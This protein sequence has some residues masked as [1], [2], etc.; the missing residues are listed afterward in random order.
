MLIFNGELK[1]SPSCGFSVATVYR[2][3]WLAFNVAL[4]YQRLMDYPFS[5]SGLVKF[6]TEFYGDLPLKSRMLTKLRPYYC[7]LQE[8]AASVPI[9]S[10]VFDI[11]CGSGLLVTFL[12]AAGRISKGA[13]VDSNA[14]AIEAAMNVTRKLKADLDFRA[15]SAPSAWPQRHFD[16]VTM[17]DVM[18]HVPPTMQLTFFGEAVDRVKP[19]GVLLYKDMCLKPTWRALANRITDLASTQQW[20]HYVPIRT[21]VHWAKQAGLSITERRNFVR[22][23]I[24]GHEMAMFQND[25]RAGRFAEQ[26]GII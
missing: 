13:G 6:A 9:D 22:W 17:I 16:V 25:N 20:I 5:T 4:R 24:F 11:G 19:G 3:N 23:Y 1:E 12:V 21:A 8:I 2:S 18:H 10:E 15:C 14:R 7:P 26:G